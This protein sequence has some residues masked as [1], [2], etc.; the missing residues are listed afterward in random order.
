METR[1]M[2]IA[3]FYATGTIVGG[4]GGPL[5]FG[6]LIQSGKPS[7]IFIGYVVGAVVMI[8]G[9]IIQATMGVEAARRDLEDIAPPLSAAG[10]EL[11]EPGEQADPYTVAP[12]EGRTASAGSPRFEREG[13]PESVPPPAA[14]GG[15][16]PAAADRDPV[17]RIRPTGGQ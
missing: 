10:E 13:A 11:E 3:F 5:L 14:T 16:E 8:V 4:F 17:T 9:G 15:G 2:A 7:Q 12:E 1:A 6:A